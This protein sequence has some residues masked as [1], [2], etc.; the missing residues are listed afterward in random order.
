M[1]AEKGI[2]DE[3]G[4]L[5]IQRKSTLARVVCPYSGGTYGACSDMC[6]LFGEPESAKHS[7]KEGAVLKLFCTTEGVFWTFKKFEDRRK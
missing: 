2:I 6:A 3:Q 5:L 7:Y 4:R 1:I